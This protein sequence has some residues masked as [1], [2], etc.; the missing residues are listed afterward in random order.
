MQSLENPHKVT[1]KNCRTKSRKTPE[2]EVRRRTLQKCRT[3]DL[4]MHPIQKCLQKHKTHRG[5]RHTASYTP[6]LLGS[7]MEHAFHISPFALP[8]SQHRAT[9]AAADHDE[10][11]VV[12]GES[13]QASGADLIGPQVKIDKTTGLGE[14][15]QSS[16][17]LF[18][19]QNGYIEWIS[20]CPPDFVYKFIGN[21]DVKPLLS[22]LSLICPTVWSESITFLTPARVQ[23]GVLLTPGKNSGSHKQFQGAGL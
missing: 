19:T 12:F 16:N 22:H 7:S 18:G 6:P 11:P 9:R 4:G 13:I 2:L 3:E 14:Q 8:P 5:T 15:H 10:A 17:G 1:W 23:P 21:K 20:I